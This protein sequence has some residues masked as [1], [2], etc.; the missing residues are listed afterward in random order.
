MVFLFLFDKICKTHLTKF[1][2]NEI[3]NIRYSCLNHEKKGKNF[4][5]FIPFSF[6][7]V[8]FCTTL[9]ICPNIVPSNSIDTLTSRDHS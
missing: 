2:S 1:N 6:T 5:Q 3:K 8:P 4:K 7:F 9:L